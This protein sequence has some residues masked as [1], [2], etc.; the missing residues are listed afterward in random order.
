MWDYIKE[1]NLQNPNDKREI[2]LDKKMKEVFVG[3][4]TVTMFSINKHLAKHIY[5]KEK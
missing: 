3:V 1:N 2:I 4:D 5:K